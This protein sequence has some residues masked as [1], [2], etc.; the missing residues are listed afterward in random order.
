MWREY[1]DLVVPLQ[2][3]RSW[4]LMGNPEAQECSQRPRPLSRG[5][6]NFSP[7]CRELGVCHTSS[8]RCWLGS[9]GGVLRG[10][11]FQLRSYKGGSGFLLLVSL[12]AHQ[13]VTP[14]PRLMAMGMGWGKGDVISFRR[15]LLVS[16][17]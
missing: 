12:D 13:Q 9:T 5:N 11:G 4:S 7:S 17:W 3:L 14:S 16:K 6:R 10:C 15:Y 2:L 1:S 8:P